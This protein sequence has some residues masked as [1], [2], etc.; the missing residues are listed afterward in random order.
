M[1]V[2]RIPISQGAFW[3]PQKRGGIAHVGAAN[4]LGRTLEKAFRGMGTCRHKRDGGSEAMSAAATLE[5]WHTDAEFHG[6]V[7]DGQILDAFVRSILMDN[8]GKLATMWTDTERLFGYERKA[9]S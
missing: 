2:S 3:H 8:L 7:A 4:Q 6:V 5:L 1:E 9:V